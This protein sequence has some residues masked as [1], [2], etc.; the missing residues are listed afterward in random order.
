MQISRSTMGSSMNSTMGSNNKYRPG[1]SSLAM[2]TGRASDSLHRPLTWRLKDSLSRTAKADAIIGRIRLQIGSASE[3]KAVLTQFEIRDSTH[4][5][6]IE[7]SVLRS[8][9]A[10]LG[11]KVSAS[12]VKG[13]SFCFE[14]PKRANMFILHFVLDTIVGLFCHLHS[15]HDFPL[16]LIFESSSTW[17]VWHVD[18]HTISKN[19]LGPMFLIQTSFLFA[20]NY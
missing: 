12:D 4:T 3:R 19:D 11:I 17:F 10:R 16:P 7:K 6:C 14:V 13:L 18:W 9:F 1:T 20:H 15:V 8:L 2:G 5:N